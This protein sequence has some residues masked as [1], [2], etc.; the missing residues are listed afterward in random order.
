VDSSTNSRPVG[1]ANGGLTIALLHLF[2][3]HLFV[4]TNQIVLKSGLNKKMQD[5]KM[6]RLATSSSAND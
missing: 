4:K 6:G 5:K 1:S 3:Q 2:V